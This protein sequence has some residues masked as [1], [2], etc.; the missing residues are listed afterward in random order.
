M[1]ELLRLRQQAKA[2]LE[3]H[4]E[5]VAVTIRRKIEPQKPR[6]KNASSESFKRM[7]ETC[8]IVSEFLRHLMPLGET[9]TNEMI[10]RVF[11]EHQGRISNPWR[12]QFNEVLDDKHRAIRELKYLRRR[13][14]EVLDRVESIDYE[15]MQQK[16]ENAAMKVIEVTCAEEEEEDLDV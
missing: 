4:D 14:N 5:L 16:K 9:V 13:I 10:E 3:E 2:F 15:E 8:P 1:N 6:Y 7:P 11:Q 12:E